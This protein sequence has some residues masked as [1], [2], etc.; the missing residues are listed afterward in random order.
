M[1]GGGVGFECLI[2]V[3][4]LSDWRVGS[5]RINVSAFGISVFDSYNRGA[6]QRGFAS[7]GN[8]GFRGEVLEFEGWDCCDGV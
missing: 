6:S 4:C 7:L 2:E 5:L 8:G 1:A 3:C